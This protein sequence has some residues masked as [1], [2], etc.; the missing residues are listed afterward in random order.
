MGSLSALHTSP[1]PSPLC[2]YTEALTSNV[3]VCE[4]AGSAGSMLRREVRQGLDLRLVLQLRGGE[5]GVS[6][7]V[8]M[9]CCIPA[10][11]TARHGLDMYCLVLLR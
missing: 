9:C 11:H 10:G 5:G 7:G 3:T 8:R 6:L 4:G 1:S 2:T